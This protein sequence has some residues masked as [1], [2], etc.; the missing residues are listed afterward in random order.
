MKIGFSILF[1]SQIGCTYIHPRKG[2]ARIIRYKF[3]TSRPNY[4]FVSPT[5]YFIFYFL[6]YL[7]FYFSPNPIP[8]VGTDLGF[9]L[10]NPTISHIS[11]YIYIQPQ[12]RTYTQKTWSD[13]LLGLYKQSYLVMGRSYI[14]ILSI[15]IH[16]VDRFISLVHNYH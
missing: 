7:Y 9:S 11:C 12:P 8:D 6:F 14:Y 3:R 2:D 5:F 16:V 13:D 4:L 15:Q 10:A 1:S